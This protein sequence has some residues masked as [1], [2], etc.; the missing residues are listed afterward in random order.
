MS[1][2]RQLTT[3]GL[4]VGGTAALVAWGPTRIPAII[5][6]ALLTLITIHEFG[7]YLAAKSV[8]VGSSEFA[9]GFGPKLLERR[10]KTMVWSLRSIPLGG[11]VRIKGMESNEPG[12]AGVEEI[13]GKAYSE[14]STWRRIW[15][16]FAGPFANFIGAAVIIIGAFLA[17]G[18]PTYNS[19][20]TEIRSIGGM[21]AA[22]IFN[23]REVVAVDGQ[24]V[25]GWESI[26]DAV[27]KSVTD[28]G[29]VSL[30]LLDNSGASETVTIVGDSNGE[31]GIVPVADY[32]KWDLGAS[33]NELGA[34]SKSIAVGIG[35]TAENIGTAIV[36]IP[37]HFA[38]TSENPE[39]R[40]ISPVGMTNI[41]SDVQNNIGTLGLL[42]LIAQFSVFL[43]L[44]NL[45]PF[46]PLDGG[47]IVVAGISRIGQIFKKG[48]EV[49]E[50]AVGVVAAGMGILILMLGVTTILLD[51]IRPISLF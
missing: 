11:F 12:E 30:T 6:L 3:A 5:I 40:L 29:E 8:G 43:G 28:N 20:T 42:L 35:A 49:P 25:T 2:E 14:V 1:K 48:W 44:F 37:A 26:G 16:S 4:V 34:V 7:H 51:I 45:L 47:H 38:G 41:A 27:R 46:P 18:V 24:K 13:P 9:V 32:N 23:Q 33:I 31:I 22:E 15:I 50:K 21:P 36:E 39:A 17:V 10:T 19:E